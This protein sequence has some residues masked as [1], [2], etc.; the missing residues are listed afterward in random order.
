MSFLSGV[1]D[2]LLNHHGDDLGQCTVIFPNRRAGLFLKKELVKKISKPAWSPETLSLEDFL[3]S[4][5]KINKADSLSLIFE[6]YQSF[7]HHQ[8][9]ADGFDS[10][11]HW[12]EMLLRDFEEVDH[13]LVDP[14]H[15][16]SLVKDEREL[17]ESF[18]FLSEEQEKIIKKFWSEF[19]PVSSKTQEQFVETWKLLFPVYET[20]KKRLKDLNVGYTSHIYRTLLGQ[21]DAINSAGEQKLIFAGFNALTPVEEQLIKH[22][23]T[24]HHAEIIWDVDRYYVDD[25]HQEAGAFFRKYRND[26]V[27]K[28]TLKLGEKSRI[29]EP[30]KV[31][32][33]GVS[34]EIGQAKLVSEK[35]SNLLE[36]GAKPEDIVVV[37]PQDYMLFPILNALPQEV[38]KLNVTM[39][40]PL[41]ETPLFGLLEAAIELQEHL[42]ISEDNG[43]SFYH[44]PVLDILN[45]PYLYRE[46]QDPIQ[47]LVTTIS[48]TNQIRIFQDEILALNSTVLNAIFLE[49]DKAKGTAHYLLGIITILSEWV[50]ERFGLERQYIYHFQ[51][52]LT[53]LGEVLEAQKLVLDT[54]T[55]KS[56]FRK[57]T[58][59]VKIPFSGE[60]VEGLQVMGAL[61][62]R[63]L[64]FKHVLMVTMN[65]GIF[66][67]SQRAGSF[68]PY[69]VRRAFGLATHE[70]QDAIYAYLFYR[71]F[72]F[73]SDLTFYHNAYADFG[74]SGEVS[75]FIRQYELESGQSI[76]KKMLSNPI[77][78]NEV[79]EICIATTSE[80]VKRLSVYTDRVPKKE[81]KRL[82]ASALNTY[83]DCK[84]RFY[85]RYVL[86][87]Y[88]GEEMSEDLDARLFGNVLH[89]TL[90]YLYQD[91]MKAKDSRIIDGEDMDR[92]EKGIGPA[93]EKAFKNEFGVKEKRKFPI[94]D[95]NVVM[96]EIIR[97]FS[98]NV[99]KMDRAYVPFQIVSLEAED[100]YQHYLPIFSNEEQINV[101]LGADIDRV[102]K[103]EGAVRIIDYKT[104]KDETDIG[105]FENIFD[106]ELSG[107]HK[108]AR[109]AGYQTFF[110]AW[111]FSCK[112]GDNDAISS[113][114][115]NIKQVFQKDF[116]FRL[117][118]NGVPIQDVRRYL[119]RFEEKLKELLTE[120][121][122][123]DVAF[124][125][126][127]E[128]SKCQFC[129]FN[130]ICGR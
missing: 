98:Q 29:K 55:F 68:I 19:I 48:S 47:Q 82:S 118:M 79:K 8:Q 1:A 22:F 58:A 107:K 83:L 38:N 34:L 15:V 46:D 56:L 7:I 90:E 66:P 23:I 113:G 103:K 116:D 99:L 60:P 110:Y 85:F 49:A 100:Q 101:K 53:R 73:S 13:Y 57:A 71:L 20:F 64:D 96:A 114:L 94:K 76:A 33:I 59:T 31:E 37:L 28:P 70:L 45:H 63:N 44:K 10:F 86:K 108:N 62:T 97:N 115:I 111:L 95:R 120:I 50:V 67:A 130:G 81:Q 80:V 117:K 12:G 21:P 3:F 129:D 78:V 35:V 77:Q 25:E 72:H 127:Q 5:S 26:P 124:S 88:G 4:F 89:R 61:E 16:F 9:Q 36:A 75:R 93:I 32:V 92:L 125:Q 106:P 128:L 104:G 105:D 42:Q 14:R 17:A 126:T 6:L 52:M 123:M 69:S 102:D 2:W 27:F 41:K 43:V 112:Y 91:V 65:E 51:Q 18:Y 122:S 119:P 24:A 11:Y 74:M 40:Y 121:F 54:K 87:L 84:L 109:K 39:G 30:K